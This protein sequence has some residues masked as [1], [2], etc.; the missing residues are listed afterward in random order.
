MRI[1][2][3]IVC[4]LTGLMFINAG[5]N[6]LFH[7]IPTPELSEQLQK[8]DA[9]FATIEWLMPLIAI[10]EI[11]GGILFII[12]KTRALGAIILFPLIV[13]IILQHIYYAPEG[14]ILAL[15]FF[16]VILWVI[17]DNRNKYL[18]LIEK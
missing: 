18:T 15:V 4:L 16:A 12:P 13:G 5:L 3:F 14:L 8:V 2:K 7:Y 17:I 1:F 10:V 6:K 11:I 9:A